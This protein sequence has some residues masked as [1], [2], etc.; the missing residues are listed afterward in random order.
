[1]DLCEILYTH[2]YQEVS[3]GALMRLI[4]VAK[5]RATSHDSEIIDLV[6]HFAH[7]GIKTPNHT[8]PPGTTLH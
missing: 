7:S 8:I 6:E 5:D 1:M 4:G 2:G 3:V